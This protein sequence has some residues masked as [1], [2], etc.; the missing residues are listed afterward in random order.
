MDWKGLHIRAARTVH[1]VLNHTLRVDGPDFS[2]SVSGDGQV[3]PNSRQLVEGVDVHFQEI[4]TLRP[5]FSTHSDFQ[6]VR[7][8]FPSGVG[9]SLIVG[10]HFSNRDRSRIERA[11]QRRSQNDPRWI[12]GQASAAFTL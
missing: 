11:I 8:A 9:P 1:S 6:S 7:A 5:E 10:T 2:F 12:V 4:Y 3:T